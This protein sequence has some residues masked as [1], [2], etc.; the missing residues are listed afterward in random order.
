MQIMP[1]IGSH[2]NS[3]QA[4]LLTL[5]AYYRRLLPKELLVSQGEGL[6]DA[7]ISQ[8]MPIALNR[9]LKSQDLL[10]QLRRVAPF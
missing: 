5:L 10:D 3:T 1:N 6:L 9:R 2:Q 4:K 8:A 7:Q